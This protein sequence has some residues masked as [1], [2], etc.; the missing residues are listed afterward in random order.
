LPD[1]IAEFETVER[2]HP[3]E[4]VRQLIERLKAAQ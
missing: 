1:A 4:R 2:L 3:S